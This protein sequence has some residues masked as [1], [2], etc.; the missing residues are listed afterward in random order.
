MREFIIKKIFDIRHL[1]KDGNIDFELI[2]RVKKILNLKEIEETEKPHKK[3]IKEEVYKKINKREVLK[4][5][6]FKDPYDLKGIPR[7][8]TETLEI[9]K[10]II[11][12]LNE[13]EKK[14]K[15]IKSKL[16]KI[17]LD[18]LEKKIETERSEI[19]FYE[20]EPSFKIELIEEK[21]KKQ[22]VFKIS[23]SFIL[24]LGMIFL[25]L[26]FSFFYFK[27]QVNKSEIILKSIEG[28]KNLYQAKSA[29]SDFSFENFDESKRYLYSAYKEFYL[30]SKKLE[31]LG[32]EVLKILAVIS[33]N[34]ILK[35]GYNTVNLGKNLSE[36]GIYFSKAF[37]LL[38]KLRLKDIILSS[39]KD[40]S[41][42]TPA[43][44]LYGTELYLKKA[45]TSLEE[46]KINLSNISINSIPVEFRKDFIT[47]KEKLPT[48]NNTIN[49]IEGNFSNIID[50]LGI[51]EQKYYLL[52]FQNNSEI[53]ATGGFIGS[54]ALIKVKDAEIQEIKVDDI[55]NIDGQLIEKIIPPK[56]IQ[57]ISTAWS[58]HDANWF[59]DFEKSAKKISWFFEKTGN[60]SPDMIIALT[61]N[62]VKD[63][64][65]LTGPIE[66]DKILLNQNN[67]LEL[68]QYRVEEV[69]KP[70]GQPKRIMAKITKK[71]L[72]KIA[73]FSPNEISKLVKIIEKNIKQKDILFYFKNEDLQKFGNEISITG[74]VIDSNYDYL[75]VVN[76]N[77]NGYKTDKVIEQNIDLSI[78]INYDGTIVDEVKVRRKHNGGDSVFPWY[79]KV[80]SNYIRIYTPLNSV[81]SEAQGHTIEE[82][83]DPIDYY[84]EGFKD[85]KDV[86]EIYSKSLKIN[87]I[88]I[89]KESKKT[90]YGAWIYVSPK[91]EV[92]F[93]IRYILPFKIDSEN[94]TYSLYLQKQPGQENNRIRVTIEFPE[95][96]KLKEKSSNLKFL[97]DNKLEF[98]SSFKTDQKVFVIFE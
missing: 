3:K 96:F 80:N 64:L 4:F 79:N 57:K 28:F 2:Y 42:I 58:T 14:E 69:D 76:S 24:T 84:K 72:E 36:A 87:G 9:Y 17:K 21:P 73:D 11:H 13:L 55:F 49:I 29:F 53:R 66:V 30:A 52:L 83:K 10:E 41:L 88:D 63:I 98:S 86:F 26:N 62:L 45:K 48:L 94:K 89:F 68:L 95:N 65:S 12:T 70:T 92:E 16:E 85:D 22:A 18:K 74:K 40:S 50:L 56:P 20:Q 33:P 15:Q 37:E 25:A 44:V 93:K 91:E 7:S 8:K 61:P 6:K 60:P 31:S 39:N 54:Y 51:N 90:V 32:K 35:T 5:K 38:S 78:K 19:Y 77:L 47:L 27:A 67:F 97:S 1:T 59:F 82:I 81:F 75:A 46:A 34:E 71:L 43:K 23:K